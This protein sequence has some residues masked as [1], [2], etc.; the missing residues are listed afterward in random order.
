MTRP[1][2]DFPRPDSATP[3]LQVRDVRACYGPIEVLHGVNLDVPAG[4][5]VGVLGPNGAGKSTTLR[6]LA[7]LH[8]PSAGDLYLAGRRINGV[9]PVRLA[10]L[11]LCMVP[12][13]RGVF[14]NLTVK[15]NLWMAT[16]RGI[17][18]KTV[19]ERA[20]AR[21]PHLVKKCDQPAGT[22]SGGEQQMLAVAR[23]VAVEPS[24]LLLDELSMG[25]APLVVEQ[26]YEAV[27]AIAAEGVTVVVVEQF[28]AAVLAVADMVAV[29]IGGR[30]VRS[31]RPD[32][33][34]DDLHTIYLG[35]AVAEPTPAG[36][37][38]AH[39]AASP[40]RVPTP[41]RLAP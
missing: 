38:R 25:L 4:S 35:G 6:L 33:I 39:A 9:D 14:P 12:E 22:L 8:Q 15:E 13:G 27:A 41:T 16:H 17:D 32:E 11:G 34:G 1:L 18:R 24:V 37:G 26:L 36:S 29:M 20:F 5:V 3:I 2:I 30:I 10:R 40:S 19:E 31:C 7:G 28:A 21:F 23:A